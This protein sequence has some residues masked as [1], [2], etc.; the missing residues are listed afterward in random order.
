MVATAAD[1]SHR[2]G[3]ALPRV[4]LSER[5]HGSTPLRSADSGR[6]VLRSAG[7]GETA[8]AE[9]GPAVPS[10]S[11][12]LHETALRQAT[13]LDQP[14]LA[15]YDAPMLE[16]PVDQCVDATRLRRTSLRVLRELVTTVV[17]ALV[18]A[19]VLN[20]WVVE[21]ALVESGPSMLPNLQIG[22]RVML[23]KV[24][25]RLHSPRRGDVVAV[26]LPAE[27]SLVVKR[28]MGLPG[29]V[30]QVRNGRVA[31]DGQTVSEPWIVYWG[32]ADTEPLTVP[33][34]HVY[35]LGDNRGNSRDSRAIGPLPVSSIRGWARLVYWPFT[36]F[37]RIR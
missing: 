28:V 26:S 10:G 21:A 6:R 4:P 18:I 33:P 16:P 25:Y 27:G 24:S 23:D 20:A 14:P 1:G 22:D 36:R 12:R 35:I 19:I 5:H 30:I 29:E 31:I 2:L 9:L 37:R 3:D 7:T 34:G 32:G 13:S 8:C 15:L 17:Q 11:A